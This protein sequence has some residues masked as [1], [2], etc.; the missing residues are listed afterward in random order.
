VDIFHERK[1]EK[2]EKKERNPESE[3]RVRRELTERR[4]SVYCDFRLWPTLKL[5]VSF[6]FP[7]PTT[8][9]LPLHLVPD[10]PPTGSQW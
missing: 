5:Y 9:I 6:T 2:R 8:I 1:G 4:V 3:M 7:H 10:R